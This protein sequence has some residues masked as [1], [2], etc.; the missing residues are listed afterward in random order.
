MAIGE[1][2]VQTLPGVH[3]C[4]AAEHAAFGIAGEGKAAREH[5]VIVE[6][7]EKLDACVEA[8]SRPGH[9]ASEYAPARPV[10]PGEPIASPQRHVAHEMGSEPRCRPD[11]S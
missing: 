3:L 11:Q 7:V 2:N 9:E 4:G 5:I 6:R 8:L 1:L 10:E